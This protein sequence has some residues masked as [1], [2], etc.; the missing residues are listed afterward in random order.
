M[1][2][3]RQLFF[4]FYLLIVLALIGTGIGVDLIWRAISEDNS[5]P[6]AIEKELTYLS[7][8]LRHEPINV[9]SRLISKLNQ[10]EKYTYTIVAA[11]QIDSSGLDLL[12]TSQNV[13][14]VENEDATLSAYYSLDEEK[15]YL[16]K[17]FRED[18]TK[19]PIRKWM[20]LIT[21]Y[22]IIAIVIYFLTKPI[23]RDLKI[24]ENATNT[25][26][27]QGL[28]SRVE[29]S[30]NSPVAHLSKA[31]NRLLDR[32]SQLLNDQK[33]MSHAISHELRTPLARIRFSLEMAQ[34]A[35]QEET[36]NAH[37]HSITEDIAEIQSLVDELLH[38]AA[39]EKDSTT[40]N[41]ERGDLVSLV[42]TQIEKHS[43]TALDKKIDLQSTQKSMSII[44]DNLLVERA[45]QNL[46]INALKYCQNTVVINLE[47]TKKKI[48]ISVE[49]DGPGIPKENQQ[50]V[51]D[52][53]YRGENKTDHKGFGLGLA[54]VKRIALLHNG[55]VYV[56]SSKLGGAKFVFSWPQRSTTLV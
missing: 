48:T 40:T 20:I 6:S 21:F 45:L 33:E 8:L 17:N 15:T 49:D 12:L 7:L 44:C 26:K 24:L 35:K 52:S 23:A 22:L 4:R 14:V 25:F 9:R 51:F 13:V 32:I 46:L 31:Y 30:A 29:M 36:K 50:Q 39:L 16:V 53:F 37:L 38:Y 34:N 18:N 56:T 43:R 1:N 27:H 11:E 41:L 55:S 47:S 2:L 42:K 10:S 3:S 54:I 19:S 5:E 28:N